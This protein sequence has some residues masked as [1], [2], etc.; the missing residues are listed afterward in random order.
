MIPL[1]RCDHTWRELVRFFFC[2]FAPSVDRVR[3]WDGRDAIAFQL[4]RGAIAEVLR[5][6]G[7]DAPYVIVPSFTC[8]AVAEAV[9]AAGK[10]PRFVDIGDDLNLDPGEVARRNDADVAAIIVPHMFGK[11]AAIERIVAEAGD[12]LVIDD[13]AS[14]AGIGDLGTHGDAGVYSFSQQKSLVAGYGGAL[15]C[16]SE[17][18]R[19]AMEGLALDRPKRAAREALAWPWA[20]RWYDRLPA[21]RY[22]VSRVLRPV[23]PRRIDAGAVRM[24]GA[25]ARVLLTQIRRMD[26]IL[27]RREQNCAALRDRLKGVDVPQYFDGCRLTRFF[28]RVDDVPALEARLK[29]RGIGAGKPYVPLH[30]LDALASFADE[31][32]P[33]TDALIPQLVGLPVQGAM[34]GADLDAIADA[35]SSAAP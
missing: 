5:R 25:Y 30:R 32:L 20:Y 26:G 9:L 34:T 33:R 31:A 3:L 23:W 12:T 16:N 4:A 15:V 6:A 29:E 17:R 27:A 13:A 18:A 35:V 24:P 19:A 8:P 14:A 7:G 22:Y 1:K 2:A 21:L 28:V 10:R 11:P